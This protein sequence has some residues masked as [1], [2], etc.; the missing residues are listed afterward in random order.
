MGVEQI[1]S[2]IKEARPNLKVIL[3]SGYTVDGP[4]R[5]ILDAGA[6][7]YLQKPYSMSEL[8]EKLKEVL[9]GK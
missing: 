2:T 6:E 9:E 4:V 3:C 1:Y 8:S 5:K 7:G